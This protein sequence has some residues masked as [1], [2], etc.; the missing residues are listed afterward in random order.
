[1]PAVTADT[2]A[3]PRLPSTAS[4][5]AQRPVVSVTTAPTGFEGEGFPVRRADHRR[6][7]PVG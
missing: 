4:D 5:A 6:R 1:M 3:L 2:V 7:H